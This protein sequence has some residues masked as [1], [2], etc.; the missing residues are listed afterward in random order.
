MKKRILLLLTVVL[1]LFLSGC[2]KME[3]AVSLNKDGSGE[4]AL[5]VAVMKDA[6]AEMDMNLNETVEK[7]KDGYKVEQ[8]DDGE[9]VG[10]IIRKEFESADGYNQ[11]IVDFS[12]EDN[13]FLKDVKMED[14]GN[15]IVIHGTVAPMEETDENA[16]SETSV[17]ENMMMQMMFS[18]INISFSVKPEGKVLSHNAT[19]LQDE[20]YVW[21]IDPTKSM[22]I[23]FEME[24]SG[25]SADSNAFFIGA[26]IVILLLIAVSALMIIILKKK[27]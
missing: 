17:M 27:K 12:Q 5:T 15:K 18:T 19:S 1:C 22:E 26:I 21:K 9:Y 24:K 13:Y 4:F 25:G 7:F 2:V 3:N 23:N 11:I 6:E 14:K 20:T 8:Y 16:D 10:Y